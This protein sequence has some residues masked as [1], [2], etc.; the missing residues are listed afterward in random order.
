M[1]KD[2]AMHD[3]K[4]NIPVILPQLSVQLEIYGMG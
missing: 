4:S 3:M 2:A 1:L